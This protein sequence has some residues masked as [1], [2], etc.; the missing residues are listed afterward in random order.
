MLRIHVNTSSE[1]NVLLE[2]GFLAT[3][4]RYIDH[5]V[6]KLCVVSDETVASLYGG[7][8]HALYQVKESGREGCLIYEGEAKEEMNK[9]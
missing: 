8:E 1:Y 4:D 2:R 5:D 6:R 3:I 9:Q 7:K